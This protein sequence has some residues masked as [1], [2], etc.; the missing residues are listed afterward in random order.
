MIKTDVTEIESAEKQWQQV[1]TES[2]AVA[3]NL[4]VG[5]GNVLE[6]TKLINFGELEIQKVVK[7]LNK[8]PVKFKPECDHKLTREYGVLKNELEPNLELLSNKISNMNNVLRILSCN[9][10]KLDNKQQGRLQT[11]C[12]GPRCTFFTLLNINLLRFMICLYVK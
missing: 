2:Q 11:S 12:E 1:L 4:A 3:K 9:G 10:Y 8:L 5:K 6:L 7:I